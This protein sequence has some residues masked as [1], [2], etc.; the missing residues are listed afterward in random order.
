MEEAKDQLRAS[1]ISYS[2]DVVGG[3][4]LQGGFIFYPVGSA[5]VT[6]STTTME[7]LRFGDAKVNTRS[8]ESRW[9]FCCYQTRSPAVYQVWSDEGMQ[10][11]CLALS[12]DG[13]IGA[14]GKT[15]AM[16]L[17]AE[18]CIWDVAAKKLTQRC[19]LHKVSS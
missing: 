6:E 19:L 3:I 16:G 12:K 17:E 10:V 13:K 18:L 1:E 14:V 4:D 11:S 9:G 5:V 2:G 15:T 8:R 7:S